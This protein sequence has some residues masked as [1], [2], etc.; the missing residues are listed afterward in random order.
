RPTTPKSKS[1]RKRDF[2]IFVDTD[3]SVVPL[4]QASQR[5]L[6]RAPL[7]VR[8]EPANSTPVP[9]PRLPDTPFPR[10][11]DDS[12]WDDKEN[13]GPMLPI[14]PPPMPVNFFRISSPAPGPPPPS[15]P[16]AHIERPEHMPARPPPRNMVLY[17]VLGLSDWNVKKTVIERAWRHTAREHHPDKVPEEEREA[18]TLRMQQVNAAKEVLTNSVR[19]FQY[20]EDGLLPWEM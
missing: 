6:K 19:R 4:G 17:D 1:G 13:W 12:F 2:T 5:R 7:V 18:A 11:P 14:T 10:S 8:G 15:S 20:H 3:A 9:S 16:P